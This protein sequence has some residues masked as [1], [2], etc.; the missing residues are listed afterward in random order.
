[1][2]PIKL[3]PL[4]E[5]GRLLLKLEELSYA[6]AQ[7]YRNSITKLYSQYNDRLGDLWQTIKDY[8]EVAEMVTKEITAN[9]IK[10][11][12]VGPDCQG[13][14]KLCQKQLINND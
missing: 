11:Q 13:Q 5:Y 10:I 3:I 6:E 12:L 8:Q 4:E 2:M 7:I 1:M 9:R 14:K